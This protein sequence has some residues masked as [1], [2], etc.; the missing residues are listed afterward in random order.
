MMMLQ[1][2]FVPI[3]FRDNNI[4]NI[5]INYTFYKKMYYPTLCLYI[6]R[7]SQKV[8]FLIED[9]TLCLNIF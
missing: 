6:L 8:V 7:C 5:S 3:I 2:I 1:Q 9:I 4:K